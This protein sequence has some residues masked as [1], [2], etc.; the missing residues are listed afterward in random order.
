MSGLKKK[1][2]GEMG[3]MIGLKPILGGDETL[4]M[5]VSDADGKIL[6]FMTW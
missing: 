5:T 1:F 2:V 4:V 3:F 6:A